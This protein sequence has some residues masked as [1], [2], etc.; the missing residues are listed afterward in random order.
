MSEY[1][2]CFLVSQNGK[3]AI[4]IVISVFTFCILLWLTY[5]LCRR[6]F[7]RE[8]DAERD[9]KGTFVILKHPTEKTGA[10][11]HYFGTEKQYIYHEGSIRSID[12]KSI[13][14]TPPPM[15]DEDLRK[16]RVGTFEFT[17][18]YYHHK[19]RLQVVIRRVT[20]YPLLQSLETSAYLYV[21]A[22]LLPD[23]SDYF[24]SELQQICE[25]NLIDEMC[26]FVVSYDELKNRL[27]KFEIHVCDRF[28]RQRMIGEKTYSLNISE[29]SNSTESSFEKI[30]FEE[31]LTDDES[32][33][34]NNA[35]TSMTPEILFSLC[36]MPTSGRLTFVAL[37]GKSLFSENKHISDIFLK[38]HLI[39]SG[40]T[41]KTVQ[42]NTAKKT[43]SPVYNEAFVFHV[44]LEKIK[45][46]TVIIKVIAEGTTNQSEELLGR[47]VTGTHA[48]SNLGRKHWEAMLHTARKPVAQWHPITA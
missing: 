39:Q 31:C 22:V 7:R 35:E 41:I 3:L 19:K 26:E 36:Y 2:D 18:T 30:E 4:F 11:Q 27:L 17:P 12:T 37:K 25:D 9:K 48:G 33:T 8:K 21:I 15:Y 23:R 32:S 46:A 28:S 40:K 44:P 20:V 42:T 10:P 47:V 38:V 13:A 6:Y 5:L 16:L 1:I 45:D 43:E 14:T 24:E 29:D 34:E